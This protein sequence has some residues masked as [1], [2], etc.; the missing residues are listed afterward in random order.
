MKE[1]VLLFFLFFILGH[2]V[3]AQSKDSNLRDLFVQILKRNIEV[4]N[5]HRSSISSGIIIHGELKN[6]TMGPIRISTILGLPVYLINDD[7][8]ANMLAVGVC[9]IDSPCIGVDKSIPFIELPPGNLVKVQFLAYC[10]DFEKEAPREN[11]KFSILDILPSD[12]HDIAIRIADYHRFTPNKDITKAAQIALWLDQG[13]H[14]EEI[15]KRLKHSYKDEEEAYA[16]LTQNLP[17]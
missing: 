5:L 16:I 1:F 13:V 7:E 11:D 12:I 2:Q 15:R 4:E 8:R 17:E 14:I 3:L 6:T 10:V 9:K